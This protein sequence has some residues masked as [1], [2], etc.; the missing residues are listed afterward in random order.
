MTTVIK[1]NKSQNEILN[2]IKEYGKLRQ[3]LD[4]KGVFN[5]A[6]TYYAVLSLTAFAGFFITAYCLVLLKS[7]PLLIICALLFSFFSVQISG[8]LHDAGH[9]TVFK[10]SLMN[11][12]LGYICGSV[13]AIGYSSWK[14]KHNMHHSHPNQE[15]EDPDLELPLFSFTKERLANKKGLAYLIRRY[16]AYL[17]YPMGM[18]VSF[19]VRVES[20][21]YMIRNWEKKKIFEAIAFGIGI[22]IWFALPFFFF[23][24]SKS[25]L[26]F[27]VINFTSGFYLLNVFAPNHKGMPQFAKNVKISFMEQQ[28]M[29]SRNIQGH[30]L[31][32]FIYMGLNYQIEHHLFP[33]TPRNK[34]KKITPHVMEICKKRNLEFTQTTIIESNKIILSQLQ[35]VAQAA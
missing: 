16:Q 29:T 21:K 17:Y 7:I 8:L 20:V 26:L 14:I 23:S 32:D 18:F 35:E 11:D 13:L 22:I 6:Y 33:N 5:R 10:S 28:I 9:R 2:G 3:D 34:L 4:K 27:F 1:K 24:L 15:E 12:I 30:W 25:L 19:S 31:T